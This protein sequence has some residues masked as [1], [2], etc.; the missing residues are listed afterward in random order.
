MKIIGV[1]VISL[2]FSSLLF[3]TYGVVVVGD[4]SVSAKDKMPILLSDVF[5]IDLSK[6]SISE[7]GYGTRYEMGGLVEVDGYSCVLV[8][9][10][11]GS[12]GVHGTFHN[13]FPYYISISP[14]SDGSLYYV[15]DPPDG[16]VNAMKSLF[17]RYAVFAQK[18]G[19]STVDKSVALNLFSRAPNNLPASQLFATR[20]VLDDIS[21]YISKEGFGFGSIVN[22]VEVPNKSLGLTFVN[23]KITFSDT[24]GLYEVSSVNVFSSEAEFTSFAFNLAKQF[25]DSLFSSSEAGDAVPD[26]SDMWSDVSLKMI[27]GQQ[28]NHPLNDVL[29]AQG[30]GINTGSAVREASKLYPFW[31][32]IFYFSRPVDNVVGV[33]VGVWG[34]TGEVAYC[35]EY[36]F[37]GGSYDSS[38][39][40]PISEPLDAGGD[41]FGSSGSANYYGYLLIGSAVLITLVSI[42]GIFVFKKKNIESVHL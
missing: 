11:G 21:L 12:V 30:T 33:Q 34:D 42:G 40:T 16:S 19:I 13:G 35:Y 10:K 27:S 6:Y 7:E 31:S 2:L 15:I 5:G 14:R 22:G 28:F 24:F 8:D 32:A 20:V 23:N 26:W 25:C 4:S 41:D 29:L 36:G 1:F 9:A 39:G 17:E 3:S 37:L 38:A 18:Y